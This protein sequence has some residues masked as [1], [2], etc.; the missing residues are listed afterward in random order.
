MKKLLKSRSWLALVFICVAVTS[1]S[2]AGCSKKQTVA[3]N[4]GGGAVT[5]E[6]ISG[7]KATSDESNAMG[8]QTIHFPYDSSDIVGEEAEKLK[9]NISILKSNDSLK[10]QIEGHCDERG[11]IQYNLALGERRAGAIARRVTAAGISKSRIT[12]ISMGKEK[13][14]ATGSNEEAWAQN[15][16]GNFVITE[17]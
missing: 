6:D 15:R 2:L 12:T 11:G 17:K 10:V 8:L 13:P 16:R 1:F 9:R 5:D 7:G 14:I 3:G 4:E